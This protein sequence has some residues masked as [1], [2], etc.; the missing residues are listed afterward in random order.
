M[1]NQVDGNLKVYETTADKKYKYYF[2]SLNGG[3]ITKDDM[4]LLKIMNA[5]EKISGDISIKIS[6]PFTP[7]IFI[8]LLIAVFYGDLMMLFTKNLSMVVF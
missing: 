5:Q 7:A 4:Y 6:Y 1:I 3:G 2:K 8:G